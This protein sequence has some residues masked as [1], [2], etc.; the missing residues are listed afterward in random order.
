MRRKSCMSQHN[1]ANI[2]KARHYKFLR[3]VFW[4][5]MT[6]FGGPQMHLN[7]FKR[8][9]VDKNPYFSLETLKEVN[10]FCSVLPGPTSTQIISV[11]GWKKGGPRLAFLTL[12]AWALPGAITMSIIALSPK[13]LETKNL[14]FIQPMVAAF[15]AYAVISM[16]PWIRKS[17]T[18]YTIFALVGLFGFLLNT[19]FIF[20][21]A[22]F[23]GGFSGFLFNKYELSEIQ[24]VEPKKIE[25]ANLIVFGLIFFIIGGGG[26]FLA[27]NPH[28]LKLSE[29]FVLF[30]NTY[31]IGAISFGGG[32]TLA[33]MSYEQYVLYNPRL[34]PQE[35]NTGL[36]L[37]QA[38]PG[39]NFNF[40]IYLNSLSIKTNGGTI[41]YQLIGCLIGFVAVFLPG[42]LIVFFAY[43]LWN[44]IENNRNIR[45]SLDGIFAATVGFVFSAALNINSTFWHTTTNLTPEKIVGIGIFITTLALLYVR[46]IPTPFIVLFVLFTG[47]LFSN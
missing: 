25:W 7:L 33:A 11:L 1:V 3:Q 30:E 45:L 18:N 40:M 31:R 38:L 14:V 37:L 16:L 15:I 28:Y 6:A 39:P 22:L 43:P 17:L 32:N 47:Y 27:E 10:A 44:R 42:L 5:G 4:L 2:R 21:I 9:L 23:L 29:P 12:L 8:R 20:P 46:R 26:L 19:P 34:S 35:F 41:L 24:V 36:G 13:F